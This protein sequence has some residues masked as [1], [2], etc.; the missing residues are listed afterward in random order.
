MKVNSNTP[1]VVIIH[2]KSGSNSAQWITAACSVAT[3]AAAG[4]AAKA[5]LEQTE[6]LSEVTAAVKNPMKAVRGRFSKKDK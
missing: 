4:F 2:V 6:K 5:V 1:G 3:L